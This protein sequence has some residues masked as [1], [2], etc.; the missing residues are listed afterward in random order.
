ACNPWGGLELAFG[1]ART[2]AGGTSRFT[3][4]VVQAKALLR[5]LDD[6]A[7]GLGIVAG[8]TRHPAREHDNGWP[9]DPFVNVPLSVAVLRDT[10]FAHFNA[11]AVRERESGRTLGIWAF[12]NEVRLREDVFL[13]A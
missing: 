6:N 5:P 1:A 13:T 10:W 9:G 3:D 2:R 12:G 4:V 11:G 8:T 7:W